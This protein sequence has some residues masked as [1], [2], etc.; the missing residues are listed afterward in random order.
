[1]KNFFGYIISFPTVLVNR[2]GVFQRKNEGL[3]FQKAVGKYLI[4]IGIYDIIK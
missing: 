2:F 1:M 3:N 4:P